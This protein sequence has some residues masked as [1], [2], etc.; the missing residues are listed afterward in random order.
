MPEGSFEDLFQ[1][2]SEMKN[3]AE[4]LPPDQRKSYAEKMAVA[5]WR[6]IGGSESEVEGLSSEEEN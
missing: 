6:S 3:K 4:N 5:F 2:L 1:Q